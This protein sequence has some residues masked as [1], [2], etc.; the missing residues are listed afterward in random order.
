MTN[1]T[2]DYKIPDIA[3]NGDLMQFDGFHYGPDKD[4]KGDLICDDMTVFVRRDEVRA[5]VPSCSGSLEILDTHGARFELAMFAG[6][7]FESVFN[8]IIAW[9]AGRDA[10]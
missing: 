4:Y 1:D 3:F 7:D 6:F 5:V 10:S 2:D 9:R 8:R